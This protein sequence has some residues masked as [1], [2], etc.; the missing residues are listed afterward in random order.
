VPRWKTDKHNDSD[1]KADETASKTAATQH[2]ANTT[3]VPTSFIREAVAQ[4][5]HVVANRGP[6]RAADDAN[7][8]NG[9]DGEEQVLVGPV[10][11]VLVHGCLSWG[12][13][14][15]TGPLYNWACR[16]SG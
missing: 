11:P 2:Q 4:R 12:G 7:I 15:N 10:I 14:A 6:F 5:P 1:E 3:Y 13:R 16:K 8:L 9:Q